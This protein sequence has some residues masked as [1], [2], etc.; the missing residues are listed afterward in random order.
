M[1]LEPLDA[2]TSHLPVRVRFGDGVLAQ[3]PEV[4]DGLGARRPIVFVDAAVARLPAVAAA[5]GAAATVHTL[6]PGEPSIDDV[7]AA[8]EYVA[9]HDAVIAIGGGS[10]LDTAKGARVVAGAGGSIR[11]FAWP[12]EPEPIPA[13]AIPL[14]TIPTTSGTGSEVTGGIVMVDRERELKCGAASPNNRAQDCLVDPQLTHALPAAPTLYGGLDVL[15]QAIGAIVTVTHTPVADALAAEALRLVADALPAVVADGADAGARNRMACASLLAGF[16]M[17]L[18]EAGTDHSLG[19]ALGV[20]H[21]IPHG[22]SVGVMLAEAMDHDRRAVPDRFER[23]A[24]ALGAP[25]A[26]DRDGARAVRAVRSL[27]ARVGCPTLGALGVGGD[28]VAPLTEIALRAWIPVEPA[29][30]SPDDIAGAYRH[31]LAI[32][33]RTDPEE[34]GHAGGPAGVA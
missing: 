28:D 3:L 20:R 26:P 13:P 1:G 11:R 24:D 14:V 27:L 4:L 31:A 22:L 30:W 32:S 9:G 19:H 18:S 6:Q 33:G 17:N 16:A 21:G 2:F 10:V 7:D 12:G 23:V 25:P 29:P 8:A 15:A 5:L 34:E